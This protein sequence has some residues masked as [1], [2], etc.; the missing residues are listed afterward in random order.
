MQR[1]LV[2][3]LSDEGVGES[4]EPAEDAEGDG[5]HA[6]D[7][8]DDAAG[9]GPQWGPRTSLGHGGLLFSWS[10]RPADAGVRRKS[11]GV[12]DVS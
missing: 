9:L 5:R 11:Y 12:P 7:H 2:Q 4:I 8:A 6:D 3:V 10:F 1:D